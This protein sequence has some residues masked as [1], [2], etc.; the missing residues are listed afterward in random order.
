MFGPLPVDDIM[1]MLSSA[2]SLFCLLKHLYDSNGSA[3][4]TMAIGLVSIGGA[5]RNATFCVHVDI[6]C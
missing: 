3:S 4:G 5:G 6:A 1:Y 2:G